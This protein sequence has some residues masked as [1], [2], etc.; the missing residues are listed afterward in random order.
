MWELTIVCPT[1]LTGVLWGPSTQVTVRV[2][3][4][5]ERGHRTWVLVFSNP[6]ALIAVRE[7][8]ESG[9]GVAGEKLW[10]HGRT[11]LLNPQCEWGALYASRPPP[12]SLLHTLILVWTNKVLSCVELWVCP[13]LSDDTWSFV[14]SILLSLSTVSLQCHLCVYCPLATLHP[15]LRPSLHDSQEINF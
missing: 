6:R 12:V 3:M 2:G 9:H 14:T 15:V 8:W 5:C 7:T 13:L 10:C 4:E 1:Y 11:N